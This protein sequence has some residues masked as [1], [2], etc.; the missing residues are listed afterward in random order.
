MRKKY[1][2]Q[3]D[4]LGDKSEILWKFNGIM[5]DNDYGLHKIN[6]YK[7]IELLITKDKTSG[8]FNSNEI[9]VS[10][11][12]ELHE[13]IVKYVKPISKISDHT[14]PYFDLSWSEIENN[15]LK[16]IDEEEESLYKLKLLGF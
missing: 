13:F 3:I 4:I 5:Y 9:A 1:W 7:K 11:L 14:K 2:E 8:W 16:F 10:T 12:Y 15:E 6:D